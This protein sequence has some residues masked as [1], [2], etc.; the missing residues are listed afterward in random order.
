MAKTLDALRHISTM[1]RHLLYCDQELVLLAVLLDMGFSSGRV[2]MDPLIN[3]IV[4]RHKNPALMLTKE[5]YPAVGRMIRPK[6]NG[7]AA[8]S[9][10]TH[11]L[12]SAWENRDESIWGYYFTTQQDGT[13]K[14]PTNGE[15]IAQMANFLS[16]WEACKEAVLYEEECFGTAANLH[17]GQAASR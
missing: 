2:G 7:R 15:F 8:E 9:A 6:M 11:L 14:K 5:V 12:D 1:A 4:M 10:I 13:V 3:A 16:L 17:V